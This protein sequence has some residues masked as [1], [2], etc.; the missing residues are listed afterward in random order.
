MKTFTQRKLHGVDR[1]LVIRGGAIGDFV[2]TLPAIKLLRERW[3]EARLEI[4]GYQQIAALAENRFYADA[5]RSLE[6]GALAS[7]FVKGAELPREFRAYFGSFDL[8]VSYLYD[9]ERVF[10][11]NIRRC[12]AGRF[13]ACSPKI[14]DDKHAARQLAAP[15]EELEL[16][17]SSP[18]AELFPNDDDHAAAATLLPERSKP[19]IALHP[20]SGSATKNW[21]LGYWVELGNRLTAPDARLVVIAGE[22]ERAQLA[23][24][25]RAWSDLPVSYVVDQPLP[26][27]AAVIARCALFI[28]HDSGISHIAAAVGTSSLL[29]FGPSDPAVWAPQNSRVHVLRARSGVVGDLQPG[30]V[31]QA[32]ANLSAAAKS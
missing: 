3:P 27:V 13:R 26:H 7:F 9:P 6:D 17:L 4:L 16:K 20:G 25:H 5:V 15:L 24:L 23:E 12:G 19:L 30:A 18:A 28:G 8:I 29:L 31:R 10:E 2:L 32:W 14:T 1:V 21:P 22:A 11:T